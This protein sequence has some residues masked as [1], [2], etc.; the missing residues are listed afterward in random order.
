VL[1]KGVRKAI[2]VQTKKTKRH[3]N[4]DQTLCSTC[5]SR[6]RDLD[7]SDE[8]MLFLFLFFLESFQAQCYD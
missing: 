1:L 8:Q 6:G 5:D 3:P 2:F 7:Q 4:E